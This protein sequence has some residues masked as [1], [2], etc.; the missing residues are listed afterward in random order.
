MQE[1]LL[2]HK[3]AIAA[4]VV[5]LIIAG[6]SFFLITGLQADISTS[7]AGAV[8]P[9][10]LNKDVKTFYEIQN[11]VKF[12]NLSFIKKPFYSKLRPYTV[13]I[14]L[15]EPTGRPNPFLPLPGSAGSNP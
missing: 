7:S 13:E 10:L 3:N 5:V 8:N 15:V 1:Q 9:A 6:G 4:V 11:T 12:D 2:N 14:P